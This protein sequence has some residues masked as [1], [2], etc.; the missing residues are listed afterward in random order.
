MSVLLATGP[1]SWFGSGS[2]SNLEP[3][4]CNGF[5]HT[6][7]QNVAIEPVVQPK[8]R[9]F[10]LTTFAPIKYLSSD[11]IV[12]WSV[13]RLCI[14]SRSFPSRF[15]KCDA[16]NIRCVGIENPQISHQIW[17]YFTATQQIVVA[18]KF[19]M[20]EVKELLKLHNLRTDHVMIRS[21]PKNLIGAKEPR[22]LKEV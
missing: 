2:G 7:T 19:W 11:C 13:H 4:C 20:R 14:S 5:C 9:R 8:S 12:T 3:D 16:T 18:S 6:K 1:N 22:K 21:E 10:N 15:Q 17:P